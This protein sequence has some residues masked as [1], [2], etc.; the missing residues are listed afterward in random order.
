V[1][2]SFSS[3]D[4]QLAEMSS[5]ALPQLQY[6]KT[7]LS[8][9]FFGDVVPNK[10]GNMAPAV[11]PHVSAIEVM[12][13]ES[14]SGTDQRAGSYKTTFE[15]VNSFGPCLGD[16]WLQVDRAAG[17]AAGDGTRTSRDSA[18]YFLDWEGYEMID[19]VELHVDSICKFRVT[20]EEMIDRIVN[21]MNDSE[22]Q[23]L[24]AGALGMMSVAERKRAAFTAQTLHVKLLLPFDSSNVLPIC[25]AGKR[26]KLHIFFRTL[27]DVLHSATAITT[28]YAVGAN[29]CNLVAEMF[30]Y[31]EN[32]LNGFISAANSVGSQGHVFN[33]VD[34]EFH[35]REPIT[36]TDGT[37]L[38][39]STTLAPLQLRNL[40]STAFAVGVKLRYQNDLVSQQ[41]LHRN[42][43]LPFRTI[44]LIDGSNNNVVNLE[45]QQRN[46]VATAVNSRSV[47]DLMKILPDA[48]PGL[49]Y[50]IPLVDKSL[51]NG[52]IKGD[53]FA[54]G[55]ELAKYNNLRFTATINSCLANTGDV[56]LY[57]VG[58]DVLEQTAGAATNN[59][60]TRNLYLDVYALTYNKF[61]LKNGTYH[62]MYNR[63]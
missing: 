22:R 11:V 40:V 7:P 58:M 34:R 20:G 10:K 19:R 56:R 32:V 29:T 4:Q 23:I 54:G 25:A 35:S 14:R 52:A 1:P 49:Q 43:T 44:G 18:P 39:T 50:F 59:G 45:Y 53:L 15:I 8:S 62:C 27:Q 47:Q 13:P 60:E 61:I 51:I 9:P 36:V 37:V 55:R 63:F 24:A 21:H 26:L 38:A 28:G 2:V 16:L 30:H 42:Y 5:H 48:A 17:A 31:P 57:G 33:Y 3:I 12:A 41:Y 6:T 46:G